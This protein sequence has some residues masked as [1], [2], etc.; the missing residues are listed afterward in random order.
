MALWPLHRRFGVKRIIASSYQAVSGSGQK[1]I[2]EL[3]DQVIAD[4]YLRD[5]KKK[6]YP[7]QIAYNVIPQIG[8]FLE[9]GYTEEEKKL[10]SEGRKIMNHPDFKASVT[11][12]R[13]PVYRCHSVAVAAEFEDRV[14]MDKVFAAFRGASGL[15]M[16]SEHNREEYPTPLDVTGKN[17]CYVGRVRKDSVFENGLSFWVV[18][19]QLLKG[20][21]LNAVQIAE[22]VVRLH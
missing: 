10:E 22:E 18:G 8:S 1:G 16:I 4:L 20:A 9:S 21:A 3:E 17:D 6:V 19:D 5:I 14:D 11:C 2:V 13:V 7:H 15:K 12:V